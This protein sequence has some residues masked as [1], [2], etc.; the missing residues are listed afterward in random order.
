MD[1]FWRRVYQAVGMGQTAFHVESFVDSET[2]RPYFNTHCFSVNP[3][4]GLLRSWWN[5]FKALASD[6]EFQAGACRDE[7]HRIFL[8]QAVLSA[9]FTKSLDWKRIR[10]LPGEYSYPVHLHQGVPQARRLPALNSVV[11]AAYEE[12]DDLTALDA[13]EPLKQWLLERLRI[14]G[15][16]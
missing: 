10:L 3:S 12:S 5:H 14:D 15:G 7:L 16:S 4:L 11:C 8:H 6:Q 2:I 13:R 9:L 1:G